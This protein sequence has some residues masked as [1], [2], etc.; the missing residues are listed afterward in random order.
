M[1]DSD[2]LSSLKAAIEPETV[3]SLT[4]SPSAEMKDE[5]SLS[6]V[7]RIAHG[8]EITVQRW[9]HERGSGTADPMAVNSLQDRGRARMRNSEVARSR[10]N[11]GYS[12]I[13]LCFV[14]QTNCVLDG[15]FQALRSDG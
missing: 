4:D 7:D 6:C 2:A 11:R 15:Y 1:F 3:L 12:E 9:G 5:K 13:D 8:F 10:T 14:K